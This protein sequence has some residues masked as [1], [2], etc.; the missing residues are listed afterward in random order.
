MLFSFI[1]K[2]KPNALDIRKAT[3]SDHLAWLEKTDGV[4]IAGPL[5]S[6]DGV[7][8]GSLLVVEHADLQVAR[9]WAATDPYARASLFESVEIAA[10]TKVIGA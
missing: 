9:D 3:R 7:P 8:E 5:L 4:Y 2:D 6:A 1:C 10:W